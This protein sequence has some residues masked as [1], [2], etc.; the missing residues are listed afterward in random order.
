MNDIHFVLTLV[1]SLL[2]ASP[3]LSA[4]PAS[5]ELANAAT[6]YI[7]GYTGT[8]ID[9]DYFKISVPA[10]RTLTVIMAA[11]LRTKASTC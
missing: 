9:Q 5:E 3:S 2:I 11:L 7:V 8:S 10:G 6:G 1:L 4:I